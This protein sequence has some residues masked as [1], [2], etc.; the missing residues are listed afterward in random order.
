V[1]TK[2]VEKTSVGPVEA[3]HVVEKLLDASRSGLEETGRYIVLHVRHAKV[4]Y[5]RVWFT[6][7]A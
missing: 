6:T 4:S 2:C 7:L 5:V 3:V 1:R